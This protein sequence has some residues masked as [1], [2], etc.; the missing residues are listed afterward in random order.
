MNN[1]EPLVI[2]Y[3]SDVLCIWAWIAQRRIEEMKE[4]WGEQV[5]LRRHYINLFGDT[6][7]RMAKQWGE[8]GGYEGFGRHVQDAAAPYDN[9]PVN[10]EIWKTVRPKSSLNA[11]LVLKAC[12]LA[13]SPQ[14][15]ADLMLL[16]QK[17]FF[18]D[19]LD[20]GL[21]DNVLLLAKQSGMDSDA[22]KTLI[23]EGDAAALLMS[24]YQKAAELNIKGSPSWIMNNGRQEL[25]GNVGYRILRANIKEVLSKP[26]Y[27][28]S[29]C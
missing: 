2:D 3:F 16:V 5:L 25:F 9:A 20:V 8:R 10:P 27:E 4:E 23:D 21:L 19:N 15:S 29:W 24:D 7:T 11:H 22:L 18:V 6:K 14:R 28:A 26:G 13:Y 12:E 1:N 17:S